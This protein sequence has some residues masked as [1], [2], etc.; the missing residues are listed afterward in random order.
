MTDARA[1]AMI[2]TVHTIAWALFVACILGIFY[3]AGRGRLLAA[4]LSIAAVM[5]EVAILAW[6]GMKCPLTAIAARYTD[7][8]ED[9][10]DIYL[11]LRLARYNKEIFGSL[12][13]AGIVYTLFVWLR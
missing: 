3:F 12:Y 11:P 10:F 4:G 1:L 5:G 2:K 6:N 9:N 7:D 13:V 8:R